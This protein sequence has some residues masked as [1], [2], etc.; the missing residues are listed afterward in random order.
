MG[1]GG[2]EL[3]MGSSADGGSRVWKA[4]VDLGRRIDEGLH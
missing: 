4:V 2:K 1:L 3:E